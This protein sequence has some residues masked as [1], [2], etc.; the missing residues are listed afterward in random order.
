MVS[1]CVV[2][3]FTVVHVLLCVGSMYDTYLKTEARR[4]LQ[5]FLSLCIFFFE[6]RFLPKPRNQQALEILMFLFPTTLKWQVCMATFNFLN[7]YMFIKQTNQELTM[8]LSPQLDFWY[9]DA[10]HDVAANMTVDFRVSEKDSQT[11]QSILEQHK[12]N[13]Q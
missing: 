4:N 13:Y 8:G 12:M 7:I 2:S 11:I 1:V 3:V 6:K 5:M 9:P 10:T